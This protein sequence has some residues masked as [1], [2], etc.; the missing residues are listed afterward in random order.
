MTKIQID[1]RDREHTNASE[2]KFDLASQPYKT[3]G[4]I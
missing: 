3:A 1:T 2:A 4:S